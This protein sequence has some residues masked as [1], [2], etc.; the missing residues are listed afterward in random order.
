MTLP[1]L[2]S[3]IWDGDDAEY[4]TYIDMNRVEYNA[5]II[6][7]E[8]GIDQVA[9]IETTRADQFRYD[10]AQK[11]ENLIREIGS[12]L[13]VSVST[14]TTWSYNRTISY[15]DFERWEAN[16]WALYRALGGVGQ[17]I[18]AGRV[19]VN[20][21]A[22]LFP[23]SWRGNGPYYI[24]LDMPAVHPDTEAMSFVTHTADI[25]QRM[26]EYNA[27][28]RIVP[29]SDRRVRI[30]ALSMLPKVNIPIT[31]AIGGLQM[32]EE[33]NLTVSGWVGSGP[34]TQDVSVPER[35]TEAI[36]GQWEGMS[37]QAVEQMASAI[38]SVSAIENN[39]IRIR[40][41]G[42]KPTID[43]NPVLLYDVSDSE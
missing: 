1:E 4:F 32:K 28:L 13:G 29:L 33:L 37:D 19:L 20:Y 18:P 40:A 25:D 31:I 6:A 7:K 21:H 22:T 38:L 14:E 24:D 5:N 39:V 10:E 30:Y 3:K 2:M 27:L 41:L 42:E 43:L 16:T 36:I 12:R 17:R 11:L 15:V 34:W 9:F 8:I 23:G 26:A 35:A